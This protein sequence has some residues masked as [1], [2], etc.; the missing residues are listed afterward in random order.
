[1][2]RLG[3]TDEDERELWQELLDLAESAP[4]PWMLIGAQMVALHAW[5]AEVRPMRSSRDGDVL[6]DVRSQPTGTSDIARHLVEHGFEMEGPGWTGLGHEFRRGGVRLDVLA[7][8]NLGERANVRTLG[9]ARTVRVPGGTQAFRRAQEVRVKLGEREGR[10]VIPDLL[11]AIVLKIRA[12]QVDDEPEAQR[13]DVALLLSL[14]VD[15]DAMASACTR[16]DRRHLRRHP[17]FGDADARVYADMP[18]AR[19][20][21]ATYRRLAA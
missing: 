2:L 14:A 3:I 12:I 21:A 17:E 4:A 13:A 9:T 18:Q 20:A 5:L 7:P 6:V 1:M 10:I 11:G 8:D 16:T 15:R 19:E